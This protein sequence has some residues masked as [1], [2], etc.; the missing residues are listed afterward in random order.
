MKKILKTLFVVIDVSSKTHVLC[1]LNF[2]TINL[3]PK[4]F[5]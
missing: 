5:K 4:D 2:E 3:L 1:A